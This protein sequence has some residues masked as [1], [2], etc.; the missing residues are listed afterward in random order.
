MRG[1]RSAQGNEAPKFAKMG[2]TAE[3]GLEPPG[4]IL[5]LVSSRQSLVSRFLIATEIP[6]KEKGKAPLPHPP[7]PLFLATH[8]WD[9][10]G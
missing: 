4:L 5:N 10:P 6:A 9:K 8:G 2:G 7:T 1:E 3:S